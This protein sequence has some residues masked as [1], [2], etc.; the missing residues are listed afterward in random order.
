MPGAGDAHVYPGTPHTPDIEQGIRTLGA[1]SKPIFLSEYGIGSLMNAVRELRYYEQN[2]FA[3]MPPNPEWEDFEYFRSTV[4]K[5]NA[6]WTRLGM[7]GTY[8]FP[9]DMLRDSQRL[10]CRQR[11]L[12]FDLIR[13]NPKICGYNLTGLLDHG[14]TG[15]G[16]WTYWREWKPGIT[17][18]LENGWA[19]LRWCA[20]VSPMH[21]Y[22]NRPL[23][24]E[25]VLA[26]ED[27]LRPG[28]YPVTLRVVGPKG[29]AWEQKTKVAIAQPAPGEDGPLALPVFAGDVTLPGPAGTYEF[30]V[31]MDSGGAP[32]GGRLKFYLSDPTGAPPLNEKVTVWGIDDKTQ[33]WL[34][35][36]GIAL[37]P[38]EQPAAEGR[39]VILVGDV[40]SADVAP[41]TELLKRIA[42]G[43]VAIFLAP[44]AFK[45]GDNAVG[46]LPLKNKGR[47]NE[48]P[49]WLYHKECIAKAH[50][51]FDGLQ[52]KGIMDWD[53]Y[54]PVISH[55]FFEGSDT[56]DETIAAA[57]ALCHSAMPG[58][59]AAGVMIG[60]YRFGEGK[61]I[62]NTFNVLANL[63][64]HPAA[65]R[66]LLNLIRY[67]AETRGANPLPPLPAD[68]DAQLKAIGFE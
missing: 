68:F 53:Y 28:D 1:D 47:G 60:A 34:K 56:P 21:G 18:A 62:L 54:G 7:D 26:N 8:A 59:Y 57:F 58:G 33:A 43:G 4:E 66:L 15:E 32:L 48:F 63:D 44:Q 13:S 38:F 29:V 9:E 67:A 37:S 23:K 20:F 27:V 65:D 51:I 19:P 22:V 41:R 6:D 11:L 25:A 17:D 12:G 39:E 3:G 2:G 10:H 64:R 5:L 61:F 49:D 16:L 35:D 45:R 50:P 42:R 36:R 46:W 14:F 24:L 30:A 40:S 52:P 31:N 55:F